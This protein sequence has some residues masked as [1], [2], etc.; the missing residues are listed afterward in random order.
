ML[1]ATEF[2]CIVI[3]KKEDT[4]VCH[5]GLTTIYLLHLV[6]TNL[7]QNSTLETERVKRMKQVFTNIT[8]LHQFLYCLIFLS[9]LNIRKV[10]ASAWTLWKSE[11]LI[12]V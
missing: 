10:A 8:A 6:L 5:I 2:I 11:G 4:S 7:F 12:I 3:S 1:V 9:M